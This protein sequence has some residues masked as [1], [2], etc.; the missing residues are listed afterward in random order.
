MKNN[1]NLYQFRRLIELLLTAFLS[2]D[3]GLIRRWSISKLSKTK[4]L[5]IGRVFTILVVAECK[6]LF[7]KTSFLQFDTDTI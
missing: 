2:C 1:P 3:R 6:C 7:G 5:D 4:P